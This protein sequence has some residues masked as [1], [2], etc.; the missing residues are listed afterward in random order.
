MSV[1]TRPELQKLSLKQIEAALGKATKVTKSGSDTVY[2]YEANKT[3][4]LR[5][6]ISADTGKVDHI[7]VYAPADTVNNMAG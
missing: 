1:P 3:F 5:F 7:S 2:T 4:E 6:I